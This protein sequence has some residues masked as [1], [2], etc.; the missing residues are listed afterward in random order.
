MNNVIDIKCTG[1]KPPKGD[2][3]I[4]IDLTNAKDLGEFYRTLQEYTD[5]YDDDG[6]DNITSSGDR[7]SGTLSLLEDSDESY[8]PRDIMAVSYTHLA[9]PTKRIV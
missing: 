1:K 3:P 2:E 6:L 5:L 7:K 8:K 9:L 4:F